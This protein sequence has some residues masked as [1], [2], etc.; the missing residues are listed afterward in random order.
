MN[1]AATSWLVVRIKRDNFYITLKISMTYDE[2]SINARL[3][4]ARTDHNEENQYNTFV[5]AIYISQ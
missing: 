5:N 2:Q 1:V 4:R 3:M